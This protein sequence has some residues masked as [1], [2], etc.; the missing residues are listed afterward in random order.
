ME[1]FISVVMPVFNGGKYLQ[2]AIES[3][4]NQT[5]TNFEL[6]IVNDGS[7]DNSKEIIEG[8][9]DNRIVLINQNNKGVSIALNNG[10]RKAKGE[11]IARMD[12]DDICF[13]ERLKKQ[14]EFFEKN[15]DYVVVGSNALIIDQDGAFIYESNNPILFNPLTNLYPPLFHSSVMFRRKDIINCG[16]YNEEVSHLNAFED[17]L[18]WIDMMELGKIG[19]LEESL[20]QYRVHPS[21]VTSKLGKEGKLISQLLTEYKKT[22][23]LDKAKLNQILFIKKNTPLFK[24][25]AMYYTFIA[26]RYLYDNDSPIKAMSNIIKSIRKDPF[27]FKNLLY[28]FLCF[29]PFKIRKL[30]R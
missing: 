13:P 8:V 20:L 22:R 3:V 10:I 16:Y 14:I 26:K 28:L 7:T 2:L 24:K 9:N 19:N 29:I 12:S 1:P 6:V 4:L 11:Y 30:N 25:Q 15:P 21:S 23:K 5:Y 27:Y 17:Q 18:L